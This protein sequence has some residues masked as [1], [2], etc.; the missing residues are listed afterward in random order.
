MQIL[1]SS[2]RAPLQ[3][4]K[5][6]GIAPLVSTLLGCRQRHGRNVQQLKQPNEAGDSIR[7]LSSLAKMHKRRTKTFELNKH[8]RTQCIRQAVAAAIVAAVKKQV[9]NSVTGCNF[10]GAHGS[11]T[12][13]DGS[14]GIRSWMV[15]TITT[16]F[17]VIST[18][19]IM[20]SSSSQESSVQDVP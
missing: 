9:T 3:V 10:S 12:R 8:S 16:K 19:F 5:L 20:R 11:G 6:E 4:C 13:T 2:P 17:L 14:T 15:F 18:T 1:V 7:R